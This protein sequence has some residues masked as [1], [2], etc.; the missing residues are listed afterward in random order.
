[1]ARDA[2]GP[3]VVV[4]SKGTHMASRMATKAVNYHARTAQAMKGLKGRKDLK[5]TKSKTGSGPVNTTTKKQS[6]LKLL[7]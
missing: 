5:P 1:M 6:V 3:P 4:V 7:A 2:A